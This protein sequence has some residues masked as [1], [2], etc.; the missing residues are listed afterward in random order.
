MTVRLP[1]LQLLSP[2]AL[3]VAAERILANPTSNVQRVSVNEIYTFATATTQFLEIGGLA[4][5]M[6][7]GVGSPD[8]TARLC[9]HLQELGFLPA[10]FTA[11]EPREET[12]HG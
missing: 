4:A 1:E 7:A 8:E 11:P 12:P 6:V 5:R 2:S 9:Q 10:S 3:A